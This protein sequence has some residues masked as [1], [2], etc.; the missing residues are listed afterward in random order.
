MRFPSF[1]AL[2]WRE[3][4]LCPR[5]DPSPCSLTTTGTFAGRVDRAARD[6][7]LVAGGDALLDWSIDDYFLEGFGH[8]WRGRYVR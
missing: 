5:S 6:V 4:W 7:K 1:V 8:V 2:L 3:T